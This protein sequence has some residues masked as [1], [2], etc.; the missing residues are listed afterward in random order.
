MRFLQV[1]V[2]PSPPAPPSRKP[3]PSVY[4]HRSAAGPPGVPPKIRAANPR[5]TSPGNCQFS[6]NFGTMSTAN[7]KNISF[8]A[9]LSVLYWGLELAKNGKTPAGLQRFK[10]LDGRGVG[11]HRQFVGGSEH[12]INPVILLSWKSSSIAKWQAR[13]HPLGGPWDFRRWIYELRRRK[14]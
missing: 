2:L 3:S 11:C 13:Y 4:G 10:C 6:W 1:G 8:T 9:A 5:K 14:R 12:A 7:E